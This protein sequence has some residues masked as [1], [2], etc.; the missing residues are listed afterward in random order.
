MEFL[1]V[2]E[3]A[4]ELCLPPQ[5]ILNRVHRGT[6]KG[7]KQGGIWTISREELNLFRDTLP[8]SYY[9]YTHSTP[10][11][12]TFWVGRSRASR[13]INFGQGRYNSE[14]SKIIKKWGKRRIRIEVLGAGLTAQEAGDLERETRD[15]LLAAGHP[16]THI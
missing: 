15:R 4:A 12:Q 8:R 16:L 11:G 10:G 9:V 5:Q 13:L 1:T 14:Y 6:L 3:I 7:I 2:K